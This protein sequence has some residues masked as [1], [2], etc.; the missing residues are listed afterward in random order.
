MI[1]DL[2]IAERATLASAKVIKGD[3]RNCSSILQRSGIE[4]VHVAISSPPYPADPTTPA[5]RA[6]NWLSSISSAE[7][8]VKAIKRTMVR[9]NKASIRH[10]VMPCLC[11]T[12]RR[13]QPLG[14][15]D[16][17]AVPR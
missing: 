9:Y 13:H 15:E 1:K 17:E 10:T 8:L 4:K 2:I 14:R 11:V 3:A 16:C 12:T 7:P 5:I 6:S